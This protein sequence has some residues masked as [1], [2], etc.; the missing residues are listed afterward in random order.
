MSAELIHQMY[1][2]YYQRPADPAGLIYWQ[3]QLNANG[4][5][6][7][8]GMLSAAFANAPES[9]ALYGSQ[10]LGQKISAIYLAAFERAA[11]ADEVAYW[12]A[13]INAAQIGFAVVNGAQNDDLATVNKKV[14]YFTEFVKVL[15]PLGLE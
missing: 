1:I 4:G 7:P 6:R 9:S 3:D 5:E 8:A 10:T 15:D 14:A 13:R 12:E 11:S 2:A